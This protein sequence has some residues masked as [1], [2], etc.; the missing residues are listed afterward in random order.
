MADTSLGFRYRGRR[1]G[2][3]P[4]IQRLVAAS[5]ATYHKGDIVSLANGECEIAATDDKTFLGVVNE[6]TVC[7]GVATT[8]TQIEVIVDE[9]SIFG[10]YDAN[11]RAKGAKLDIAGT[12]GAM[13]VAAD[14]N[15]DLQVYARSAAN[16]ETLVCFS[17]AAH[18]DAVTVS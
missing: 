10:V 3:P 12:T 14:S 6:T 17:H 7:D 15:H 18:V 2:G 13:T 1:C 4:T 9:D 16:E 5:A 11:A 8:G